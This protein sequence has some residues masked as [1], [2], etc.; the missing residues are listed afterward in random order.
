M[1]R[2]GLQRAMTVS[3]ATALVTSI[4]TSITACGG[5]GGNAAPPAPATPAAVAYQN[6]I[7]LGGTSPVALSVVPATTTTSA[8]LQSPVS[9]PLIAA[10]STALVSLYQ[11][12]A[13]AGAGIAC[14]SAT[15]NSIGT[16]TN[17]NVGVNVKSVAALLGSA[18]TLA[19]NQ[20]AAWSALAASGRIFDG[21][22]NCGAKAEGSPSPSSTLTANADGSFSDN[23]FDGNP[24]TTVRIVDQSFN[25]MQAA[26]ML[27]PAGLTD[28]SQPASPQIIRLAVYQNASNQTVLVEQGIPVAGASSDRPGY[29]AIYFAR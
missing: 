26:A 7:V 23:V 19:A 5:G 4:V 20:S 29:V 18:W 8:S 13:F 27:S 9:A 3:I 21:W 6:S 2:A 11:P 17:V 16:V 12:A 25:A 10:G 15:A 14:V 24:S 1:R 28:T 22:E